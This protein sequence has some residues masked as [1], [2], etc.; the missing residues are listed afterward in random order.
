MARAAR[1]GDHAAMDTM[2]L[3]YCGGASLFK[4]ERT[5]RAR[6]TLAAASLHRLTHDAVVMAWTRD[7]DV[8]CDLV[9]TLMDIH[10]HRCDRSAERTLDE[11]HLMIALELQE[12]GPDPD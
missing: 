1:R 4:D 11:L 10:L 9:A 6:R 12:L 3:P 5:A 8:M 7:P 2:T